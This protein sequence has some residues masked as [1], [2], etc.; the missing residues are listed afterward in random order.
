MSITPAEL[1]QMFIPTIFTMVS[2]HGALSISQ[3][4]FRD[5]YN[6]IR[7]WEKDESLPP[8][9]GLYGWLVMYYVRDNLKRS[10]QRLPRVGDLIQSKNSQKI[11]VV[12]FRHQPEPLTPAGYI[13]LFRMDEG[14]SEN[15]RIRVNEF[16]AGAYENVPTEGDK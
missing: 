8:R 10:Y 13:D 12:T 3:R 16:Y 14:R 11:F 5:V 1:L 2:F 6:H 9:K 7:D 4:I 15:T